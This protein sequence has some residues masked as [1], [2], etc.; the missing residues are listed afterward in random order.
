MR[1]TVKPGPGRRDGLLSGRQPADC[2]AEMLVAL[3]GLIAGLAHVVSGPDH[4]AAVAPLAVREHRQSWRT[5]L[6]WGMGHSAGVGLVAL[7]LFAVREAL[8]VEVISRWSE[9]LVGV[10]LIGIGIWTLRRALR[11]EVHAHRHEHDGAGEHD[12]VHF[13][14]EGHR[15]ATVTAHVPGVAHPHAAF[16]IGT[17]H[18]LAGSSHFLGVLPTLALPDWSSALGYLSGF[19]VGTVLAMGGF[20][21]A[22]G[23]LGQWSSRDHRTTYL[24]LV[25]FSA[26]AAIGVGCWWV[27]EGA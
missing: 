2:R 6:R 1:K 14:S 19:G 24:G 18:G 15:H 13:H 10:L 21:W 22:L 25:R 17:L 27:W 20:S 8:P 7:L 12:H 3:T 23:W 16:G 4:L 5:G 9:R 11:V 26:V